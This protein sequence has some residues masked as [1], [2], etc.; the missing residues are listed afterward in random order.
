MKRLLSAAAFSL[1]CASALAAPQAIASSANPSLITSGPPSSWRTPVVKANEPVGQS[2]LRPISDAV[3][4]TKS[5]SSVIQAA[6]SSSRSGLN[7][8]IACGFTS[9]GAMEAD[10]S[11]QEFLHNCQYGL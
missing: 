8:P 9:S 1:V 6:P 3:M 10:W 5:S 11:Y 7:Y 4:Q 2:H